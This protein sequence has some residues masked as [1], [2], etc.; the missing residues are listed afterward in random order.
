M[1][2]MYA[3]LDKMYCH[4]CIVA[5][6]SNQRLINSSSS[7][8]LSAALSR[9]AV[10]VGPI[11]SLSRFFRT[12][13]FPKGSGPDFVNA[14]LVVRAQGSAGVILEKLHAI[15]HEF[16]R[17]RETRWGQRTIDIDL[18]AVE[19]K[20]IPN[21]EIYRKWQL[22]PF[23]QQS[24]IAPDQLILPHPRMQD[25]AFVLGP[26]MEIFPDWVHPVIQKSVSQMYDEL[27][28]RDKAE[29]MPL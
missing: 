1:P 27:D 15:E 22:L 2:I 9:I 23:S 7:D 26:M 8:V 5:I 6:G 20:I 21:S 18:I 10:S 11:A 29:L 14:A 25:R 17:V 28:S 12:P 24:K 19:Q 3:K 13:A 16:G 4:D